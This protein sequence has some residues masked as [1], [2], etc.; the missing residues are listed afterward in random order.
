MMKELKNGFIQTMLGSTIWLL[1]LST[2]FRENRELSYEYIWTIVLIGALF[3]LVFGII[4][5]Y[6]WKYATYPAIINIISST[7]VNTVLGFLAVNL[8]DKTMFNLII[9]YWWCALILTVIIHSICFYFYTNYQNKQ[10][11]KELNS[12]I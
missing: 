6:L 1:L 4:Y 8:Y 2:L 5:P 9:P 10:L 3:G 7:L 11:E 12:L